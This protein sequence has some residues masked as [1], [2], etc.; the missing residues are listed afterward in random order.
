AANQQHAD[1]VG[2]RGEVRDVRV[3]TLAQDA[4]GK[5][6]DGRAASVDDGVWGVWLDS[7]SGD[8]NRALQ[9]CHRSSDGVAFQVEHHRARCDHEAVLA[10]RCRSDRVFN[11]VGA[12]RG[13]RAAAIGDVFR[14]T[15]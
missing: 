5:L 12:A 3:A 8:L 7:Y 15:G 6:T 1:L 4:P 14:T 13:H 9:I 10:G 11:K 2:G